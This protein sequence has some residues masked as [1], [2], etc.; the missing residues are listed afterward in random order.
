MAL[1]GT[2]HFVVDEVDNNM[3]M[4]KASR[5]LQ[6]TSDDENMTSGDEQRAKSEQS[7]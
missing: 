6:A 3:S 1:P 5:A 2:K 7:M 4:K